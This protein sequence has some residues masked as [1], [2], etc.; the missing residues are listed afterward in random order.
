MTCAL[1]DGRQQLKTASGTGVASFLGGV[2][3]VSFACPSDPSTGFATGLAH[4]QG[5][6]GGIAEAH[7]AAMACLSGVGGCRHATL[8]SN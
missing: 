8:F 6:L 3:H 2:G 4:H 5:R 7:A 1:R